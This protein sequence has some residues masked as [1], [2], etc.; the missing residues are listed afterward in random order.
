[1]RYAC[2]VDYNGANFS[3]WQRQNNAIT[4]QGEIERRLEQLTNYQTQITGCGRTDAGVHGLNYVFHVDF[5]DSVHLSEPIWIHKLNQLL[6]KGIA[7]RKIV[8][9]DDEFHSRYDATMRHYRFKLTTRKPVFRENEL[10]YYKYEPVLSVELLN[11]LSQLFIN[12]N[13]FAAFCKLHGGN[14]TTICNITHCHWVKYNDNE[15]HFGI[16]ANRFLRGMVRLIV[17]AHLN[18]HRGKLAISDIEKALNDQTPL[19]IVWSVSG[20]GLTLESIDYPNQIFS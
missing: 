11:T 14:K 10:T 20:S 18:Y 4:V 2:L 13:D 3:G 19:P 1:M 16:S 9:V 15:Y 17:G 12:A 7:L 6:P 5:D 8:K